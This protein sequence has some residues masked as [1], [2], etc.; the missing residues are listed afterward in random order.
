[1]YKKKASKNEKNEH[2][3][4]SKNTL[5]MHHLLRGYRICIIT[6]M[7]HTQHRLVQICKA[8]FAFIEIDLY[9]RLYKM[10]QQ[11]RRT[12]TFG[13]HWKM[14]VILKEKQDYKKKTKHK[15][16]AFT[17]IRLS[18]EDKLSKIN[19]NKRHAV[20]LKP[21]VYSTSTERNEV[22]TIRRA[23]LHVAPNNIS[24]CRWLIWNI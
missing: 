10:G 21:D 1:M 24:N 3:T 11:E 20:N 15:I 18:R 7:N 12:K 22:E 6:T 8:H 17:N 9:R 2:F 13:S 4:I 16:T 14:M 5:K 23:L 19:Y